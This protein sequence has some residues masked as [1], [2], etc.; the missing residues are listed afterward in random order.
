MQQLLLELEQEPY[1]SDGCLGHCVPTMQCVVVLQ[2]NQVHA[3]LAKGLQTLDDVFD[4]RY[5]EGLSAAGGNVVDMLTQ[6]SG[7]ERWLSCRCFC[8]G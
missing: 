5:T 6:V 3:L 2:Y 7:Q 1:N 4:G 8:H